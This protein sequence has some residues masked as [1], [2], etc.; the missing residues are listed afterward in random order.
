MYKRQTRDTV[1]ALRMAKQQGATTIAITNFKGTHI[2]KWADIDVYKR[3]ALCSEELAQM[4]AAADANGVV[5]LEAMRSAH[6]PATAAVRQALGGL[7]ALRHADLSY[8]QYS[9]CLLYTSRC[10]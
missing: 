8:C 5:L 10:V 4:Y 2:L 9:S 6:S 1:D 7:G 3:Q